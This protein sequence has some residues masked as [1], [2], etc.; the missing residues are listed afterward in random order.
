MKLPKND[1]KYHWTY[2]VA[3]KMAF[4]GISPSMVKRIIRYPQRIEEGI[5]PDTVAAMRRAETKKL[6]EIWVMYVLA[7]QENK[8]PENSKRKRSKIK[9]ITAWRFPGES[10]ERDPI[11]QEIIEEVKAL[12]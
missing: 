8:N 9:I 6:Q 11:P 1:D 12:F 4:Y 10:P 5:A 2:H 3:R 7:K